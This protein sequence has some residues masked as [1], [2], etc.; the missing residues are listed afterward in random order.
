M[1]SSNVAGAKPVKRKSASR[2]AVKV[3]KIPKPLDP[4]EPPKDPVECLL[5]LCGSN[6]NEAQQNPRTRALA[7]HFC[8]LLKLTLIVGLAVL[9]I[10]IAIN[11]Q[12][13][14][15]DFSC[16]DLQWLLPVLST[17]L[18]PCMHLESVGITVTAPGAGGAA[19]AAVV[20]DS[21]IVKYAAAGSRILLLGVVSDHQGAGSIQLTW[22]S[23]SDTTRN[24]RIAVP[25]S[26]VYNR[27]PLGVVQ[28]LEPQELIAATV[29]GSAVAGDIEN[30]VLHVFYENCPGISARGIDWEQLTTKGVRQV[31]V[32]D[33][34]TP[35]VGGAWSGNRLITAGSDLLH[36]NQ[37]YA[38]LGASLSVECCALAL[39]C[40]DTGNLRVSVPGH[41]A[42]GMMT[43]N[44]FGDLAY[45]FGL[46]LIPVFNTGNKG[47]II[48]DILQD[49]NLAAVP[50]SLNLVELAM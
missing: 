11:C 37:D 48:L 30:S 8:S 19:G 33:S 2:S 10:A 40:V 1:I 27:L 26:E 46:P 50:F 34:I 15:I 25:A 6:P 42:N 47:N 35:T 18:L 21:L 28:M 23:A 43:V 22:P 3:P 31:T 5:E 44:W 36:A 39:R 20:G 32:A 38:V 49:E 29:I 17:Q 9:G 7:K 16:S 24:I 12:R 13:L 4:M 45:E 14:S 41:D